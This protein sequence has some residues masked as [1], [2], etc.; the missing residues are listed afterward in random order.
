[1]HNSGNNYYKTNLKDLFGQK[2]F[3]LGKKVLFGQKSSFW[4]KA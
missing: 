4:K 3:S 1:M 2:K